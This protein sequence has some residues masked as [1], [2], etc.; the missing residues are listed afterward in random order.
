M[1]YLPFADTT[2]NLYAVILAGVCIGII[3]SFFGLSGSFIL[4]P[5]LNALGLPMTFAVGTNL[6]HL[7]GRSVLTTVKNNA[8]GHVN[9]KLGVITGLT[10]AGG[11][12]L[13][14]ALTLSLEEAGAAGTV[15]R[16]L[17]IALL[18]GTGAYMLFDYIRSRKAGNTVNIYARISAFAG[19]IRRI[20]L[21][22]MISLP[23]CGG[24]R[25]S[26]WFLVTLGLMTG[27]LSGVLG[28]SGSFIRLPALVFFTGLSIL[29]ALCT[30]ALATLISTGLGA[31][32]F[33]FSG[34]AEIVTAMLLLLGSGV[35]SYIGH[36]ATRHVNRMRMRLSLMAN[37]VMVFAGIILAQCGYAAPAAM[38]M[39]GSVFVLSSTLVVAM[40]GAVI[41]ESRPVVGYPVA[42]NIASNENH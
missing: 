29:P 6:T 7:F 25:I 21:C 16:V 34:H 27:L 26:L 4:T 40:V 14:K 9:W 35:G 17:Y 11:I 12:Y 15:I 41:R 23:N 33:A 3:G 19:K 1:I 32:G 5:L 42:G 31:A 39:L 8:F 24:E 22:P 13:G 18:F 10:G 38:L 20:Q 28:I 2:I 30:D 36:M 37:V